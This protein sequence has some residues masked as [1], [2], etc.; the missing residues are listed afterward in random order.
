LA[1]L[2]LEDLDMKVRCSGSLLAIFF[3]LASLCFGQS[4]GKLRGVVNLDI[5]GSPFMCQASILQLKRLQ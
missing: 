5:S 2:I 1:Q 4:S 3:S